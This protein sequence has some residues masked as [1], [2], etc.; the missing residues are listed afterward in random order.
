ME[1]VFRARAIGAVGFGIYNHLV[2]RI[3]DLQRYK[4]G[5]VGSSVVL[6]G[7]R[8]YSFQKR[9]VDFAYLVGGCFGG[10]CFHKTCHCGSVAVA[11]K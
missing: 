11:S 2:E 5:K 6:Y 7:T 9:T 1:K 3:K 8:P 4:T 10:D